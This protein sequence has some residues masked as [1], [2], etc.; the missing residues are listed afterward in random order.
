MTERRSVTVPEAAQALG[1]GK[2]LAYELVRTGRIPALRLG[3]RWVIPSH[4]IDELLAAAPKEE[5]A[6]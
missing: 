5:V 2:T 4:V 6:L 3:H 1:I